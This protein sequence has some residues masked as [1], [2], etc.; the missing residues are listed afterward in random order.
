MSNQTNETG[1]EWLLNSAW[2]FFW[3]PSKSYYI[4]TVIAD[5]FSIPDDPDLHSIDL[6]KAI[7]GACGMS[8]NNVPS[9][10][11]TLDLTTMVVSG[12]KGITSG[13]ALQFISSPDG[14]PDAQVKVSLSA[15]TLTAVGN[16]K[17]S[18]GC[19][20]ADTCPVSTAGRLIS[21]PKDD[22]DPFY[23]VKNDLEKGPPGSK[24]QWYLQLYSRYSG[25][26]ARLLSEEPL[27]SRWQ[28][29][30]G[31]IIWQ[32]IVTAIRSA[33]EGQPVDLPSEDEQQQI[34][35]FLSI[36]QEVSADLAGVIQKIW[37]DVQW[38]E[39]KTYPEVLNMALTQKAPAETEMP[40]RLAASESSNDYT[41]QESGTFED[42]FSKVTV[43]LTCDLLSENQKPKVNVSNVDLGIDNIV[44]DVKDSPAIDWLENWIANNFLK[45]TV[46]AKLE[47][48]ANSQIVREKITDGLNQGLEVFWKTL[49]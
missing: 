17:V 22:I 10:N 8:E 45:N 13:G 33:K 29:D 32:S 19:M 14:T 27:K 15:A 9:G 31:P 2:D 42:S 49:P 39:G 25:E 47:Q 23:Q 24:A 44:F 21:A 30:Q 36:M 16:W 1:T 12:L 28:E 37:P 40:A 4:P 6:E 20:I 26:V 48:K 35:D 3:D 34:L 41:T 46:I 38:S 18:Q 7:P 43:T 5:S 11:A